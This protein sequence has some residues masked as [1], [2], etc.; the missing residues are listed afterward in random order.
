MIWNAF[1]VR[2]K[3][4]CIT[5]AYDLSPKLLF[6]NN[7]LYYAIINYVQVRENK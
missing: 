2:Y 1:I 4:V 5:Y 7:I 3:F 6:K